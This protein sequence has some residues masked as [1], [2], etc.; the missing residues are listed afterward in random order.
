MAIAL[1]KQSIKHI[2]ESQN[3]CSGTI[4]LSGLELVMYE[5]K[6]KKTS[7]FI[8]QLLRKERLA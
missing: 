1:W 2:L 4:I 8:T 6:L 3:P 7:D 5:T